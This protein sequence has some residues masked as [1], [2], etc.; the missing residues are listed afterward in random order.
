MVKYVGYITLYD[1][2]KIYGATTRQVFGINPKQ[3]R[4][5]LKM[6]FTFGKNIVKVRIRKAYK[7]RR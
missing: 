4:K 1:K 7:R 6:Q 5:K 3:A 2:G